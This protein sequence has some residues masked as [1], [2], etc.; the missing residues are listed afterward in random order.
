MLCERMISTP[1]NIVYVLKIKI[2]KLH[3]SCLCLFCAYSGLQ[4]RKEKMLIQGKLVL[5]LT[6]TGYLT[7][8][9]TV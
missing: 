2:M 5:D 7:G 9:V 6:G 4:K 1:K 8:N 3:L